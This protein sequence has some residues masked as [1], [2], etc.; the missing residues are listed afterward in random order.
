MSGTCFIKHK[1][2]ELAGDEIVRLEF[3]LGGPDKCIISIATVFT[4]RTDRI[5][6]QFRRLDVHTQKVLGFFLLP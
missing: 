2:K 3:R 6:A 4:V 5:G 1:G